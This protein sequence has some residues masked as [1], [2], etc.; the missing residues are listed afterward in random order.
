MEKKMENDM[1]TGVIQ[2]FIL[3]NLIWVHAC[4]ALRVLGFENLGFRVWGLGVSGLE[5]LGGS[6]GFEDSRF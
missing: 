4:R 2:G 6:F 5:D 3:R 1:E